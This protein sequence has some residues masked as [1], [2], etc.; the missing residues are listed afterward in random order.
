MQPRNFMHAKHQQGKGLFSFMAGSIAALIAIAG[1]LFTLNNNKARDFKD[2][3]T[4]RQQPAAASSQTEVLLPG[5]VP[6]SAAKPTDNTRTTPAL[7]DNE[8]LV[9]SAPRARPPKPREETEPALIDEQPNANKDKS[10]KTETARRPPDM[11][12]DPVLGDSTETETPRDT[13]PRKPETKPADSKADNR[14]PE[15]AK[16]S[17]AEK[18]R[19][20]QEDLAD[21]NAKPT[22][23]QILNS[24][25]IEKAREVARQE[26]Q[27]KRAKQ[28]AA[29]EAQANKADR[30]PAQARESKSDQPAAAQNKTGNKTDRTT[31]QAGAYNSRQAA[32]AQRAKLALMGVNTQIVEV[33]SNGKTLYRVQ[34]RGMDSNRANQV[35]ET[36]Q[37]NGI[38]SI[39]RKQ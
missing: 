22:A 24:G 10:K 8:P 30:A 3:A 23:E 33:Q 18:R 32:E 17:E 1:V 7:E 37:Q 25:S 39:P 6:A 13:K 38:N 26:A 36:L 15:K 35:R 20:Q 14:Q 11:M 29:E 2:P 28:R 5:N 31:V 12:D 16:L 9:A 27:A 34:T 4:S 19:R 21:R